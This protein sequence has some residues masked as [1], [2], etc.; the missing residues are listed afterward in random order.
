MVDKGAVL[1]MATYAL[2]TSS[3]MDWAHVA[4]HHCSII[5]N[6]HTHLLE[7]QSVAHLSFKLPLRVAVKM[8]SDGTHGQMVR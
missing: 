5:D 2:H 6:E 7:C 3:S 1:G 4:T 8:L